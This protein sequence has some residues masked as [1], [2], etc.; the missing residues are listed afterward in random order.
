MSSI[1]PSTP[2]VSAAVLNFNGRALLEVVLPTL[3]A[4]EFDDVE[5]IVIDNCSSDDSVEY[6][7]RE[8]PNVR[9]VPTGESNV[10]VAA[11]LN[12]GVQ[13]ARGELIALLNNDI[14][15]DPRWLGE[16]VA[17][18]DRY[19]E[20]ATAAGKLLSYHDR[21]RID[22]AGDVF[23]TA[24]TALGRGHGELDRGQYERE[25]EIFAPTGG[26]GLYRASAFADVGPFDESFRAYFEDVD[27][28]LRAQLA[29]HRSRYVPGSIG[30]HMGGATTGG[31]KR[32]DYYE[33][34]RRNAIGVIVKDV[35]ARFLMRHAP[36]IAW[37][38]LLGFAYGV[39]A[40]MLVAHLR[41][42]RGAARAFPGWR[43]ERRR[44]M[45]SRRIALDDFER[46]TSAKRD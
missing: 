35:P 7:Q 16:L 3:A 28:G 44:I 31:D 6:L 15:L 22:A 8:W 29:G 4:Q 46:F 10:G 34:Q 27:W 30:Y 32:P 25:E 1:A 36:A 17:T 23:T 12:V 26:A 5:M 24:A 38:Q 43:R 9:V 18:L 21:E 33:L 45:G 19:P 2:R 20:A 13:A 42:L 41:A 39:H 40:G 37:N 14:E 11:A